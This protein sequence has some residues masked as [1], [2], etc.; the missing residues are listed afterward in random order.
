MYREAG[1]RMAALGVLVTGMLVAGGG[2]AA[3]RPPVPD[4]SASARLR[5]RTR[6][7]RAVV[8]VDGVKAGVSPVNARIACSIAHGHTVTALPLYREHY[9]Q[10]AQIPPGYLPRRITLFMDAPPVARDVAERAEEVEQI[11]AATAAETVEAVVSCQNPLPAV[12]FALDSDTLDSAALA[13]VA[14]AA[15][16]ALAGA[17]VPR[18]E[19]HGYA[20]RSGTRGHNLAL[21]LRRAQAVSG[22]LAAH[23]IQPGNI[24]VF[25][26]GA[27][28]TVRGDGYELE[29]VVHR[30]VEI[31]LVDHDG[32]GSSR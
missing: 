13:A 21:S 16:R 22:A 9:R 15:A 32:E 30:K 8:Y 7:A 4:G 27:T 28:T 29:A 10:D 5:I 11:V 23:G 26:H 6:P 31:R 2:C 14:T 19:L 12:L 17:A 25:G 3:G 20:D 24:A 1:M 18:I